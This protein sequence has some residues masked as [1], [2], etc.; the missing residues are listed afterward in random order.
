MPSARINNVNFR[1][2]KPSTGNNN[3]PIAL[4][5]KLSEHD[6]ALP[7]A[8]GADHTKWRRPAAASARDM[9]A[10]ICNPPRRPQIV[11]A[12]ANERTH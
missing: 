11:I 5:E 12:G 7:A 9:G 4:E 8:A 6:L 2:A 3:A 10:A 1:S